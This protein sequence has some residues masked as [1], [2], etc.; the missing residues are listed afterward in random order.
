M[1]AGLYAILIVL[2]DQLTKYIALKNL[3]PG[4][5]FPLIKSVFHLTLVF[6]KGGAFGVL[7]NATAF[8]IFISVLVIAGILIFLFLKRPERATSMAMVFIMAGAFSNLI[9]RLRF[10]WVVDFIDFR[11]WPVFNIADSAIT[12]GTIWLCTQYFLKSGR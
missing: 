2:S 9:D 12:I 11:V 6:N 4:E 7:A 8:F 5:S 10:G 3:L 1:I